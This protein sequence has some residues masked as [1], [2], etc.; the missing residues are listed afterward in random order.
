[1][2]QWGARQMAAAGKSA[3]DIIGFYFPGTALGRG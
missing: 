1:M 3:G 2:C